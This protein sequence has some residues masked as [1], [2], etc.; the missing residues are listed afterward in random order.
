MLCVCHYF[1]KETVLFARFSSGWAT[2]IG[3][4]FGPKMGNSIKYLAKDTAKCY[5]IGNRTKDY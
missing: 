3:R 4:L 1:N 5:R 2:A